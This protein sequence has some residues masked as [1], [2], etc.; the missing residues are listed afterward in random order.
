M[1]NKLKRSDEMSLLDRNYSVEISLVDGKVKAP[2][3]QIYSTDS[4]IFNIFVKLSKGKNEYVTNTD[5]SD[6]TVTLYAVKP[7]NDTYVELT[8]VVD[9]T[10]DR[11]LF[12]LTSGFN[13]VG[14]T[15]KC[16]FTIANGDELIGT[17]SFTYTVTLP[18]HN[19]LSPEVS[20]ASVMSMKSISP[21]D[22][23]N[24][25]IDEL[26]STKYDDFRCDGEKLDMLADGKILRSIYLNKLTMPT[27]SAKEM[28]AVKIGKGLK[29][30]KGNVSLDTKV[31]EDMVKKVIK[32]NKNGELEVTINGETKTFVEKGE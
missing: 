13:N 8:G 24:E 5:L 4:K 12:D 31:V 32:F 16:E 23:T 27:A 26:M 25:R 28:G 15:Y 18:L 14:G 3:M 11:L 10:E 19:G 20:G 7:S 29:V 1:I 22:A 2:S 30:T 6:Y 17:S 9:G 21:Y